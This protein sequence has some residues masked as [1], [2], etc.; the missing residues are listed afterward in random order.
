[1]LATARMLYPITC[2]IRS[3]SVIITGENWNNTLI[4]SENNWSVIK[5]TEE[6]DL[7]YNWLVYEPLLY[8]IMKMYINNNNSI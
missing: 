5:E 6:D 1:M 2:F 4:I 8:F 3:V 7:G